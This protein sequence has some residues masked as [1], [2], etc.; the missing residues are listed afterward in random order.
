MSVSL[1][2]VREL[3]APPS[4]LHQERGVV[5]VFFALSLF[6]LISI[7][8]LVLDIGRLEVALR[9][10]QHAADAAAIA[11]TNQ[12]DVAEVGSAD[13]ESIRYKDVKLAVLSM[14]TTGEIIGLNAAAKSAL[15]IGQA[16]GCMPSGRFNA[17]SGTPTSIDWS[18]YD[19]DTAEMGN[20]I[21]KVE[22]LIYCFAGTSLAPERKTYP[23]DGVAYTN[24]HYCK[25][26]AVQ[27]TLVL[28]NFTTYFA[29]FFGQSEINS[30]TAKGLSFQRQ[31]IPSGSGICGST[32]C[33]SIG[34]ANLSGSGTTVSC[35]APR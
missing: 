28:N 31:D 6:S 10:L 17:P 27:V 12:L 21:V 18:E 5:L 22:R 35:A 16:S 8:G 32:N 11:G 14:L 4:T 26:N 15:C 29:R 1:L 3:S 13:E 19:R 2:K 7:I 9:S 20:L 25:A 23:L 34:I 30:L 33:Q 24:Q